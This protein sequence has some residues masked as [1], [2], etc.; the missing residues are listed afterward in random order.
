MITIDS[1]YP[2]FGVSADGDNAP[3]AKTFGE[4]KFIRL[5]LSLEDAVQGTA[6]AVR[7]RVRRLPTAAERATAVD[8]LRRFKF[9]C[10]TFGRSLQLLSG[11]D[12]PEEDFD[13]EAY[14]LDGWIHCPAYWSRPVVD[15]STHAL[16]EL[17]SCGAALTGPGPI[18]TAH[19]MASLDSRALRA[20][21]FDAFRAVST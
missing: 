16:S 5:F 8:D 20:A 11:D 13:P 17:I 1:H 14:E 9:V 7:M 6:D 21:G 4:F 2:L 3:I 15:V 12:E 10:L 18:A 19:A